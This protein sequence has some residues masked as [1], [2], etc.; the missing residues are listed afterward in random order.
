MKRNTLILI[1]GEIKKVVKSHSLNLL[2]SGYECSCGS[3]CFIV[4]DGCAIK[5]V[6]HIFAVWKKISC[7]KCNEFF[8]V[9]EDG[10][11]FS[12]DPLRN[13]EVKV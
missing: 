2:I 7:F 6:E 8:E 13:D 3:K 1:C 12:K 4:E 5:G 9:P 10:L 11:N